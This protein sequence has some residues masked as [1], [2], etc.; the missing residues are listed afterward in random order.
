MNTNET[1]RNITTDRA[2][3]LSAVYP[4]II[5]KL[6]GNYKNFKM[7]YKE[8]PLIEIGTKWIKEGHDPLALVEPFDGF[9]PSQIIQSMGA[10]SLFEWLEKEHPEVIGPVNPHNAEIERI[11]GDQGGY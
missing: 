6:S 1:I 4:K 3:E 10:D 8:Y 11:F 7:I 2:I 5:E 9:H